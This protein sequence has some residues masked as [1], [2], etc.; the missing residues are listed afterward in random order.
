MQVE[1]F[2]QRNLNPSETMPFDASQNLE[3]W[4]A[5]VTELVESAAKQLG[6]NDAD[7]AAVGHSGLL[8]VAGRTVAIIPLTDRDDGQLSLLLS[9]DTDRVISAS[10]VTQVLQHAPGALVSFSAAMGSSPEGKWVLHRSLSVSSSD[11]V[12]LAEAILSSV[13]LVDF[14][15]D[16]P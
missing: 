4:L 5:R 2:T 1:A 6:L 15:F 3:T 8:T 7:A 13:Q 11:G 16:S 12:V 14:V 10:E 9:V